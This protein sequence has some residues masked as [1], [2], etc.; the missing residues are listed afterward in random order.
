[1]LI[2]VTIFGTDYTR[3]KVDRKRYL[4]VLLVEEWSKGKMDQEREKGVFGGKLA[5][6]TGV[7]SYVR[8]GAVCQTRGPS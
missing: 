7:N 4:L 1:L 5:S 2:I 6:R 8:V 3:N